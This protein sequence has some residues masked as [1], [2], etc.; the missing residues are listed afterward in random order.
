MTDPLEQQIA[1]TLTAEELTQRREELLPGLIRQAVEATELPDGL[2]LRFEN[3]PGLSDTIARTI[4]QERSCCRFLRFA[5]TFEPEM[6]PI[7]VEV[8]GPSGARDLLRSL[9]KP[10]TVA[11]LAKAMGMLASSQKRNTK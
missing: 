11:N 6:G 1:C 7:I 2:R 5:V 3:R 4:D 10:S 9:I 8:T